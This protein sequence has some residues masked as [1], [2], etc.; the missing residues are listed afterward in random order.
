MRVI[1]AK[2]GPDDHIRGINAVSQALRDAG[3]EVIFMGTGQRVDGVVAAAVEED[4]D[5]IGLGFH[6]G[7]QLET[8]RRLMA[9][10]RERGLDHIAVIVGGVIPPQLVDKL[11]E[12]GV[13][14]VFPPGSRLEAIVEFVRGTIAARR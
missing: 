2:I 13:A 12:E 5:V 14:A 11:R 7:G 9:G 10:L 4:V 6:Y 3:M 1:T 8:T